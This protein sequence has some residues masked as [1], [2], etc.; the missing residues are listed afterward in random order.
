MFAVEMIVDATN[1]RIGSPACRW[2]FPE[3]YGSGFWFVFFGVIVPI[4]R[5][6]ANAN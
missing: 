6:C 1:K 3:P 2:F 5:L 4:P